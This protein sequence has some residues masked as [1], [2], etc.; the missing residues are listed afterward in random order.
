MAQILSIINLP[1]S[2]VHRLYLYFSRL[3][4][5]YKIM[6]Y[7]LQSVPS[8]YLF[9]H[10]NGQHSKMFK[11][12]HF[13]SVLY[14]NRKFRCAQIINNVTLELIHLQTFLLSYLFL[15]GYVTVAIYVSCFFQN[16]KMTKLSSSK[17]LR[18]HSCNRWYFT[19]FINQ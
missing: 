11:W 9:K 12:F 4:R 18:T 6:F 13:A 3:Y 5:F 16:S 2:C 14:Y 1:V 8:Q 7:L 19:I 15:A 10:A 17:I